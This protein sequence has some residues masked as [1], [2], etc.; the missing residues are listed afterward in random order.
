MTTCN[1]VPCT[2]LQLEV[3]VVSISSLFE[4]RWTTATGATIHVPLTLAHS[5]VSRMTATGE[6]WFMMRALAS[7]FIG[8]G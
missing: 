6:L 8:A 7:H 5:G 3:S 2:C 4:G 1:T